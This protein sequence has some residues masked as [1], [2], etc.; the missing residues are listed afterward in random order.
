MCPLVNIAG[1]VERGAGPNIII[2]NLP[3]VTIQSCMAAVGQIL[4]A[5]NFLQV[6]EKS[7]RLRMGTYRDG[8]KMKGD[9]IGM[10]L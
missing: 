6:N 8:V 7:C 5:F 4:N 10:G 2:N 1:C 9:K 3:V